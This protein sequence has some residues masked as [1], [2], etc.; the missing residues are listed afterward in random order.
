MSFIS[1][2]VRQQGILEVVSKHATIHETQF[3][4]KGKDF[5]RSDMNVQVTFVDLNF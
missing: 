4:I 3:S 5:D 2:A 1:Q